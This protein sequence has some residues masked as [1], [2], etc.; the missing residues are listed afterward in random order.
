[1]KTRTGRQYT[2]GVLCRL[3][4]VPVRASPVTIVFDCLPEREIFDNFWF[5]PVEFLWSRGETD[6]CSVC[7]SRSHS[8][9]LGVN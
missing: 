3:V 2:R 6:D 4:L 5:L 9:L 7:Y 1:M 8:Q